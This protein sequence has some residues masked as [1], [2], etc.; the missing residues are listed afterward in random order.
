LETSVCQLAGTVPNAPIAWFIAQ[1]RRLGPWSLPMKNRTLSLLGILSLAFWQLPDLYAAEA[2]SIPLS[3]LAPLSARQDYGELQLDRSVQGQTLK[4]GDRE[5]A[6]G[7]GTHA[8]SRV[9][10]DLGGRCARFEAWVG[11]DAEMAG[12]TNSTVVFQ[13]FGDDQKLF[14]SG[15][16][17]LATPAQPVNVDVRGVKALALVVTDA[18]DGINCDHADWAEARVFAATPLAGQ[19]APPESDRSPQYEIR[20]RN[21][22]VKLSANG[23][24]VGAEIAG[25]ANELSGG[26]RFGG[27]CVQVG[28]TKVK[29]PWV[30]GGVE[31]TRQLRQLTSDKTFTVVERFKPAG[32][33]VR[34]EFEVVSAGAPWTTD[35][36]TELKYPATAA[37]RFWT[38]WSDPEHM[39][40]EWRDPLV[41]RPLANLAWTFGGPVL[42]GDYSALPLATLAEPAG[43]YGFSLVFSPDDPILA[44]ARLATTSSGGIRYSRTHY[45]LGGGQPVRF[46]QN[47][48]AHEADW[49]GGLRWITGRYPQF[50]E[51]PNPQADAMAGCGAYSGAED[52]V[53]VAKLKKMGFRINWKLS[54]DFPYMGMFLPPV[55]NAD[56]K[57]ERSCDENAPADKP[58]WTTCHRLNDYARYMKTNGFYVLDYFNVTEFGKH[59]GGEPVRQPGDPQ[60]WKD[61]CAF[62]KYA[63]PEAVLIPGN[64]TCYEA[65]VVDAGDPSFQQ[66]LLEQADRHLRWLPDSSGICID[67]LDWLDRVN[68][69]ADDGLSWVN[70]QPARSLCVSWN[71]LLA[72]L[73]PM[74]HDAHK[75]IFV[76]PIY[77]R[78]DLLRQIDGIYTE[79]GNEGRAL[80]TG[81]LLGLRKPVLAWSYNETLQQ[82]D[83]DSFF[84]RHL[85]LGVY[86]TAPYPWNN[87]CITPEP[88][89]DQAYLDY[90][91]LLDAM[92]GKKWVLA[93]HCVQV[94]GEV[95]K[96][97][98]F[99]VPGGYAL[100]VVLG[101][102]AGFADIV[103]RN[104]PD[105]S[106]IKCAVLH[107]GVESA[108]P[109]VPTERAC[110]ITLRV[111]LQRGCALVRLQK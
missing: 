34:W 96:A 61:P 62:L 2:L 21:L 78:L 12:Y 85:L 88:S 79:Q 77:A 9:V 105:I 4:I 52:P 19:I 70:G 45:R 26:T 11:V 111:P 73:G 54:D 16:L 63:L 41:L 98:L 71:R 10:Y 35:I 22:A 87:H 13:V 48:V 24:I 29:R 55:T 28:A 69:R 31:F 102:K 47:L 76:N 75:V 1:M 90:G 23:E 39:V 57:W 59:M 51:P 89:A 106:A 91:P 8:N 104:L 84:Q 93:P 107:P 25:H 49:R 60:L 64:A 42:N 66:F 38:A 101:G 44:G 65:S 14:D 20:A 83:P 82:P 74:L 58:R 94:A 46:T 50:F 56:E 40:G 17:R 6:R 30:G 86:P 53:D 15:V 33:S 99:Q 95:A 109:L 100:P 72:K 7:L 37:T 108:S 110:A 68:N 36:T 5:F 81:A 97:N 67:R 43:D 92:R 18:G 3:E 80:N 32:D 103:I 27:G